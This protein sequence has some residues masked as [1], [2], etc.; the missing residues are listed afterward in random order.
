M[1][2]IRQASPAEM[3]EFWNGRYA[4]FRERICADMEAGREE[5]WLIRDEDAGKWVGELHIV[6]DKPGKPWAANGTD[7]A[8]LEAFRIEEEY[9]GKRLGTMLMGRCVNRIREKGCSCATIGAD[10]SDARLGEMYKKW[11]FTDRVREDAFDF[12]A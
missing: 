12:E 3:L 4:D 5:C 8:S 9:Q 2:M 6:W 7:T 10:D 1:F 11:G